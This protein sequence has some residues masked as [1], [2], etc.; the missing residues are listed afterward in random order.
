M[1]VEKNKKV[2]SLLVKAKEIMV[3][4]QQYETA[5]Q[6]RTIERSIIDKLNVYEDLKEKEFKLSFTTFKQYEEFLDGLKEQ[7]PD[8]YKEFINQYDEQHK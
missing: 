2:I 8:I 4:E 7:Y 1:N 3:R 5:S 6:I